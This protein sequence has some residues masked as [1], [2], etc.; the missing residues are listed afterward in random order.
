[1]V[2]ANLSGLRI[3]DDSLQVEKPL[4]H[5]PSRL[6][7][8]LSAPTEREKELTY[9]FHDHVIIMCYL[10][11]FAL[12]STAPFFVRVWLADARICVTEGSNSPSTQK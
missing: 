2:S 8:A 1:M 5:R 11:L 7:S 4:R 9:T 12:S 10:H 6:L 3:F